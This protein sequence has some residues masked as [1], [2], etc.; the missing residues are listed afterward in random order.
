SIVYND[1]L[2][3]LIDELNLF[4]AENQYVNDLS[5]A[6][7]YHNSPKLIDCMAQLFK[8]N[9]VSYNASYTFLKDKKQEQEQE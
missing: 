4:F 7:S 5:G 9:G 1:K 3:D 2:C 6:M 8:C